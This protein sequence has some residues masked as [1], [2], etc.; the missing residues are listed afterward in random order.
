[1]QNA[2]KFNGPAPEKI[3]GRLAMMALAVVC[4]T[5]VLTGVAVLDQAQSPSWG[6][7][8]AMVLIVYASMVPIRAGAIDEPFGVFTPAAERVNGRLAMLAFAA[9]VALEWYTGVPFF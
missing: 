1:M 4:R 6:V 9:L 8:A 5:E 3:N 2:L 7:A